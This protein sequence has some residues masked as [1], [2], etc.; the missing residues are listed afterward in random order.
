M[1][2]R[3]PDFFIVGA[4]KC[5]TTAMY[6]Y[7][8]QHPQVF[9]AEAKEL[10][11]FGADLLK[12][13]TPRLSEA[14]YLSYFSGAGDARRVG[15]ASVRYL[16]SRSAAEEIRR[17]APDGRIIVM[18][19]DPVEMMH[20]Q[21]GEHLFLGMEDIADFGE[22]LAAEED[23]KRGD[24]IP[25]ATNTADALFYRESARFSDQ[26]QRY[27]EAFGRE[28]VHVVIYD[29][30]REDTAREY[31]RT[32]EFLEVDPDFAPAFRVVNPAKRARSATLRDFVAD[33]P[34]A[35]RRLLW[36]TT[37]RRFRK[38]VT[39][40]FQR[41]NARPASRAAIDPEL[42]TRLK[43]ELA[44]EVARLSELLGRDLTYWSRA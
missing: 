5:A 32:L 25:A 6:E 10:H 40:A 11:Y 22:A 12:R 3:R 9:M 43:A 26:L 20:A 4:P 37:S 17:F 15:E 31:R 29:D 23:R 41:W 8:R 33:P 39:G 19:R 1:T 27:F 16:Q 18:L 34:P 2:P 42:R 36:A 21:H 28:R 13:R 14:E 24:R 35:V 30:F 44:P 38:R 7:L